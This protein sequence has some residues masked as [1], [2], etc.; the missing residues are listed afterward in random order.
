MGNGTEYVKHA[1]MVKLN[2]VIA[3]HKK[4]A[5][6]FSPFGAD[7]EL[8]KFHAGAAAAITK[9]AGKKILKDTGGGCSVCGDRP[10][11]NVDGTYW[12]CGPCVNERLDTRPE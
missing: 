1:T 10:A 8:T 11:V 5:E 9:A 3:W 2:I 4:Q 12:L 6:Y 7:N